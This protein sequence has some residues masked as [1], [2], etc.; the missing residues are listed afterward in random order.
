MNTL[1]LFPTPVSFYKFNR[2]LSKEEIDFIKNQEKTKNTG[3]ET[4]LNRNVFDDPIMKD[5]SD[6][7]QR[8]IDEYFESVYAPLHDVHLEV[9]QSWLNYTKPGQF[10][11]KH[12]HPNSLVSGC[13]YVSANS[14]KDKIYFYE[15]TYERIAIPTENFNLY[16]SKSWWVP[17]GT[18]DVIL[19]PSS[20]THMVETVQDDESR[21]ERISI[22]F[23]TFPKGYIGSDENLTGLHL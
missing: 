10:H 1:N 7:V 5:I 14:E 16:N 21:E 12:S 15:E 4:S 17:V 20:L 2:E 9:T 19:F 18:L 11:H 13:F 23:N 8:C 3:N 22:S 6:F